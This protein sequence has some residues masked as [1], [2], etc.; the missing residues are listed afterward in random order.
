MLHAR[1]L[2]RPRTAKPVARARSTPVEPVARTLKVT[3]A[4]CVTAAGE[5]WR[6]ASIFAISRVQ[7]CRKRHS[8]ATAAGLVAAR[9][10]FGGLGPRLTGG[11][12]TRPSPASAAQPG[13]PSRAAPRHSHGRRLAE[14]PVAVEE[15][16]D[17][18]APLGKSPGP[19]RASRRRCG[20]PRR[21]SPVAGAVVARVQSRSLRP[22]CGHDGD[23]ALGIEGAWPD[24]AD[25]AVLDGEARAVDHDG[26][27]ANSSGIR[28][29]SRFASALSAG[30]PT[31]SSE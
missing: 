23:V 19:A 30:P 26:V 25:H 21:R 5:E 31:S 16:R 28:L 9:G 4:M 14:P 13:R 7:A 1:F 6:Y 17:D 2:R 15:A 22:S 27:P 24:D 29:A 11:V 20:R 8:E 3:A 12:A 10:R 18:A